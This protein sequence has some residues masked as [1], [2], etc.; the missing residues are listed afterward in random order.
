MFIC[1]F[2]VLFGIYIEML[3]ETGGAANVMPS[4]QYRKYMVDNADIIRAINSKIN[5]D[6]GQ[7]VSPIIDSDHRP[8]YLYTSIYDRHAT[9]GIPN[10][11]VRE[12]FLNAMQSQV[13]PPTVRSVSD[14]RKICGV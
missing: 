9:P 10:N 4:W 14:M 12:R 1:L 2:I 13:V 7:S 11:E 8:P 3:T 6:P 5:T